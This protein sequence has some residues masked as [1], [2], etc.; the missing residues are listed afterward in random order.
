MKW[1]RSLF[2]LLL[3]TSCGHRDDRRII[4]ILNGAFNR[5]FL[6]ERA[7]RVGERPVIVDSGIGRTQR[8]T[9]IFTLPPSEATVYF[10]RLQYKSYRIPFIHDSTGLTILYNYGK[11]HYRFENSPASSEWQRFQTGQ[12]SIGAEMHKLEGLPEA[13]IRPRLDSLLR[14]SYNRNFHYFADT[15]T[16]PALFLLA[17]KLVD[18]DRDYAG[19]E[20]FMQRV[21]RRFPGHSGISALVNSTL[22]YVRIFNNPLKTGD[23]LPALQLPDST[24]RMI[25]IAPE[26]NKYL[27]IDF[28][29][30]WC[31]E[32]CRTFSEVKKQ[33]YRRSDTTKLAMISIAIDAEE[34]DWRKIIHSEAYPWPQLID[35]KMW[36][37]PAPSTLRFDSLPFNFLVAPGGRIVGKAIPADSLLRI[38]RENRVLH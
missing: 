36:S 13:T 15:T 3:L 24:G 20:K 31:G 19:L 34:E 21:A 16:N 9:I 22:D 30:S 8:D 17:Y 33:I 7:G 28:W 1:A 6:V 11:D 18:F 4:F 14:M 26:K 35:K 32:S 5:H 27:L 2:F 29:S 38:L 25:A 10:I 12:D 37:G 23:Q